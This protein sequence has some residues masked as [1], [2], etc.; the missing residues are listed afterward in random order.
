MVGLTVEMPELRRFAELLEAFQKE[1]KDKV[2][3]KG[4]RKVAKMVRDD[5]AANERGKTGASL[6][7]RTKNTPEG[8]IAFVEPGKGRFPV[9]SGE[10][11]VGIRYF[12]P[13]RVAHLIERGTVPRVTRKGYARGAMKARPFLEPAARLNAGRVEE[14]VGKLLHQELT[15]LAKAK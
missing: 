3:R 14:T 2:L 9:P 4:M 6:K 8:L 10:G 15:R 7:V 11:F 5:A 12:A 13:R 1:L